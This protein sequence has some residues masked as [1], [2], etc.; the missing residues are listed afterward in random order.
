MMSKNAPFLSPPPPLPPPPPPSPKSPAV[1]CGVKLAPSQKEPV[2]SYHP[3]D[4]AICLKPCEY[5]GSDKS[6]ETM[7][8]AAAIRN[9][10]VYKRIDQNPRFRFHMNND[11]YKRYTHKKSLDAIRVQREKENTYEQEDAGA[12]VSVS[13]SEHVFR[14]P[15]RALPELAKQKRRE[16]DDRSPSPV[17]RKMVCHSPL[18]ESGSN[19]LK[20]SQS[21]PRPSNF[22]VSNHAVRR[23]QSCA[24]PPPRIDEEKGPEDIECIICSKLSH[25]KIYCKYRVR[26]DSRVDAFVTAATYFQDDVYTRISD[27]LTG[28]SIKAIRHKIYAADI[29]YHGACMSAY[30]LR[31]QRIMKSLN[32]NNDDD[33]EDPEGGASHSEVEKRKALF[34]KAA[35]EIKPL[36]MQGYCF[37]VKEMT[38]YMLSFDEAAQLSL[39]LHNYIVRRLLDDH[40]RE[41]IGFTSNV[42]KN[43]SDIFFSSEISAEALTVKLKNIDEFKAAG[44]GLRRLARGVDFGLEDS[45]CDATDVKNAWESTIIPD[46]WLTFLCSLYGISKTKALKQ[47][48]APDLPDDEEDEDEDYI[49]CRSHT[50]SNHGEEEESKAIKNKHQQLF[51]IFQILAYTINDGRK[52]T[53]LHTM[54]GQYVYGKTRS[55]N[56]ITAMNKIGCSTGY[57]RTRKN[58]VLLAAYAVKSAADGHVRQ[59]PNS[60]KGDNFI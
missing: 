6:R 20:R 47:K 48:Q 53:P 55:K 8:N 10:E 35:A 18:A 42:R 34:D 58:R 56:I 59:K 11:C 30:M 57:D 16:E 19:Q 51:S 4:C 15:E 1:S 24:R 5:E 26:M 39:P 52:K 46:N 37:T 60:L 14:E 38:E 45:L 32:T 2:P 9:D 12:G 36:F 33:S 17:P 50:E 31:Y 54:M 41:D 7:R 13:Q 29:Y 43:E 27:A 25:N 49:P 28:F 3:D 21:S 44:E 22:C 23:S 40:F